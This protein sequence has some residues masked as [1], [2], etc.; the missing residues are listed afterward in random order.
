[1]QEDEEFHGMQKFLENRG[2]RRI[3]VVMVL[4]ILTIFS[5][6]D[7]FSEMIITTHDG[8]VLKVPVSGK[9]I[10]TIEFGKEE[11]FLSIE[12]IWNS[13]IGFQYSITQRG[14]TF[15]WNVITPIR[16][17]GKGTISD[18]G[19]QASWSGANGSG[20]AS[21]RISGMDSSNRAKRIEWNNGVVF[22]R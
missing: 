3:I 20:S 17:E 12:G 7:G 13:S 21:G 5:T 14:N 6:G 16:E 15:T 10:K 11:T 18:M 4:A 9:D 8:K 22:F 1:L 2:M 19:I